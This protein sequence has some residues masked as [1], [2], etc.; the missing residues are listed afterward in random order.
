[1]VDVFVRYLG[2]DPELARETLANREFQ[3]HLVVH[4]P[5]HPARAFGEAVESEQPRSAP[6][7]QPPPEPLTVTGPLPDGE[8]RSKRRHLY[9]LY[10]PSLDVSRPGRTDCYDRRLVK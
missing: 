10:S 9:I 7:P 6:R 2:G 1:V 8:Q 4:E 3:E 5:E